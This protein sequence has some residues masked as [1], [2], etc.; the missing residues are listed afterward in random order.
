MVSPIYLKH[1]LPYNLVLREG[2]EPSLTAYLANR[3]YKSRR[4]TITLP[5]YILA[6]SI[7]FEPMH[8]FLND[9][10][11]NCCLNRSANSPYTI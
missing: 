5:E 8:P 7:G 4:A 2:L 3:G 10:L 9:S 1:S 6:E 11:A